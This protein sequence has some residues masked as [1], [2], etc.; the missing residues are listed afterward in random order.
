M[1]YWVWLD[2][3]SNHCKSSFSI[4]MTLML[5][6]INSERRVS[7]F[8][9]VLNFAQ[10]VGFVEVV[11]WISRNCYMYLSK[12]T[13]KFLLDLL[14]GFVKIETGISQSCYMDLLKLLHGFIKVVLCFSRPL[15]NKTKLKF[16]QD[17]KNCWNYCS[18]ISQLTESKHLMPWV[19]CAF[20]IVFLENPNWK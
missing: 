16:N 4:D 19:Q 1:Q 20:V 8:L 6:D 13:H 10:I 2:V 7:H 3:R 14:H 18:E 15:P 12:L 17:F 9:L 5:L 11:A